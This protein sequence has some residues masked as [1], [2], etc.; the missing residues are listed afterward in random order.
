MIKVAAYVHFISKGN[1][2]A[3]IVLDN[4]EDVAFQRLAIKMHSPVKEQTDTFVY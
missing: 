2:K 4:C 1:H 3:N